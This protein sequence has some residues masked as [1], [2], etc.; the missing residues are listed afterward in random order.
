V[1]NPYI[2]SF[3]Y[4]DALVGG[5]FH[6]DFDLEGDTLEEVVAAFKKS[7]PSEDWLGTKADIKRFL[8]T[9]EEHE[10]NADFV[11]LFQPGVDPVAWSGSTQNWLTAIYNLL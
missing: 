9:R 10:I 7:S 5:W 3:P 2:E 6:Q 11:R 1:E 4:L 8:R